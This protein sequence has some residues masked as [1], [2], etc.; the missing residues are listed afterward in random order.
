[1][2]KGIYKRTEETKEKMRQAKTG[3]RLSS[4]TKKRIS[5]ANM[6]HQV[7][8]ETRNKISQAKMGHLTSDKT[9]EKISKTMKEQYKKGERLSPSH[10]LEARKKIGLA[11]LK[12]PTLPKAY[13]LGKKR[14]SMEWLKTPEVA[15]K[16]EIKIAEYWKNLPLEEKRKNRKLH[17]KL[18]LKS[19]QDPKFVAK[20]MKARGVKLNKQELHLNT[21]LQSILPN[22]YK[23]V[24]DGE[25]ILVGKCPDF[26][27]IN[28]Q[29]KI[30]ELY[31]DYWHRNDIPQDRIDLFAKYG[32]Q[33]LIIWERELKK[34][35]SLKAKVIE[36][37]RNV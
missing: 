20:Q 2:P 36:F 24:G 15:K 1:M 31:G 37:N 13:W 35:V 17:R 32:Y 28:G 14:G 22:E 23:F 12:N 18:A 25:F 16:K 26:V 11:K 33:T 10:S 6:G 21:F 27:N 9:R 4:E 3:S 34:E 5:R 29:K 7:S 19:W 8:N 30:I